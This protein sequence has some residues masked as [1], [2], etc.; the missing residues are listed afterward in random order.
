MQF[1]AYLHVS[2][3]LW[4]VVFRELRALTNDKKM[5]LNPMELNNVYEDL[6][7]VGDLL[8]SDGCFDMLEND[9]RPWA[10][11]RSETEVGLKFYAIHDRN[12]TD[13][14]RMLRAYQNREDS[15][16]YQ[17]VLRDVLR[18]FGE[19]IHESL[20]RTMGDYLE[21]TNGHLRNSTKTEWESEVASRMVCTNN[22]AEG[23]FATVRA[24][25]HIYPSLKLRTVAGL[26]AAMVNGTHRSIGKQEAIPP[27]LIPIL[28]YLSLPILIVIGNRDNTTAG[29]AFTA[30][31]RLR[32]AITKVCS[33]RTHSLGTITIFLRESNVVDA[34]EAIV[35]RKVSKEKKLQESARLQAGRLQNFNNA[36]ET[37]LA[38]T[39]EELQTQIRVT[40]LSSFN[41]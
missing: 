40:F 3:I 30:P 26:S 36:S 41:Q 1:E 25:M 28:Y 33:V 12:R 34:V 20:M 23:P 19:A 29:L 17:P 6:W 10:K 35:H 14:L 2:A 27:F 13:E 15:D 22:H 16:V 31:L 38:Q 5:A 9:Y 7:A 8:V 21:A 24:F 32:N 18:L 39:V 11:L 37:L 4:R